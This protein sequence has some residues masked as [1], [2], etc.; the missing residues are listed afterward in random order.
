[1][2]LEALSLMV[3]LVDID[4]N[5]LAC[6]RIVFHTVP[7]KEAADVA[8]VSWCPRQGASAG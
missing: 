1:M 4:T 5:G 3:A 8:I 6:V 2:A 7:G